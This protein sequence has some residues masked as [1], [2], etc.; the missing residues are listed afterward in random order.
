M[1]SPTNR[2][3]NFHRFARFGHDDLDLRVAGA[4]LVGEPLAR[5]VVAVA[6]Q[7]HARLDFA[8]EVQQVLAVGV[9]GQVE[10]LA[11]RTAACTS[12]ALGLKMNV[13]PGLAALSRPPGVSGSA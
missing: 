3:L 12:P 11:L 1:R 8:D 9:R 6:E 4:D 2:P 7:H 13:S 10:V 5:V